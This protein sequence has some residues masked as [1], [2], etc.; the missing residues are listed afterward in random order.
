MEHLKRTSSR[1]GGSNTYTMEMQPPPSS[2]TS[3]QNLA[4][5]SQVMGR[6][7][8]SISALDTPPEPEAPA[9][10]LQR[11]NEPRVNIVRVFSTFYSFMILGAN[12]GAYGA[13]I[14]YIQ[15]YY[16]IDYIIVSLVFLSSVVGYVASSLLNNPI[17]LRFG[18]RG[19]AVIMSVSHIIAY[20]LICLHV[21]YPA[22]VISF[23]VAGFGNGVGDAAW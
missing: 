10:V 14:P 19:I 18:Q 5:S 1:G 21:P 6:D 16:G 15:K 8:P 12:D 20:T 22:L 17:H 23:I 11:W 9:I 2:K 4:E 13:L 3:Q 7:S